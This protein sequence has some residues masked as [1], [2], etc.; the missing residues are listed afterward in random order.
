MKAIFLFLII[1]IF[2]SIPNSFG[3]KKKIDSLHAL[4]VKNQNN[5]LLKAE[6]FA[7]E[8]L[9]LSKKLKNDSLILISTNYLISILY[10]KRESKEVLK[11]VLQN[12]NL[13]KKLSSQKYLCL[14]YL[15][16]AKVQRILG[17]YEK[18]IKSVEKGLLISRNKGFLSLEHQL[19]N[20]KAVLLKKTKRFKD[21]KK[22][23]KKLLREEKFNDLNNISF[24]YNS[25][26]GLYLR[27]DRKIDSSNYFFKKG[28][29]L[30][31]KTNNKYLQTLLFTNYS[32]F[33]SENGNPK[34]ALNYLKKAKELAESSYNFKSLFFINSSLGYYYSKNKNYTEAIKHYKIALNK[35]GKYADGVQI[36]NNY[37]LLADV[38]YY[39]KQYKEGFLYV[40]KVIY[41]N[42]SLFNIEK[43]KTFEKLQ[44]E[45][46]VEK[47]NNKITYLEKEKELKN[48]RLKLV[49]GIGGLVV[50]IL[51][52]LVFIYRNKIQAQKRI[53]IQNKK[54]YQQE[55]EQLQQAQKIKRIEGFIAGEE[56]EKNRIATELHDGIGGEL[57][58]IQHFVSALPNSE[59]TD[60]L[61]K[62]IA[63]VSKEVRLLAHSLSS[64]FSIQQP[65]TNLLATLQER[66]K[67][68][69]TIEVAIY[70]E[71]E[72]DTLP[73]DKKLF[74]YRAIQEIVTNIYKHA[75]ANLV[76]ISLTVAN[77]I[78]LL[79]EDNGI[80][81]DTKATPNGIG[82]ENIKEKV[83]SFK[84]T[85]EVD[86]F[87]GKGTTVI[88]KISK[89]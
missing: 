55:K 58:G 47:K 39:D 54:L 65:F 48:Q 62:D 1:I 33:F 3:Q 34:E 9:N 5:N 21:S 57:S 26:A 24:T 23:L 14:S 31:E 61:S 50:L 28:I 75:K 10:K 72:I 86:S 43:N 63:A 30:A 8:A 53:A 22:L 12:R 29:E 69:F 18:S 25:L 80:G 49:Y 70:P 6:L 38:L 81:F 27:Q 52:L 88:I 71:N 78:T 36:A 45:F 19:L 82:L 84:G 67:N 83:T 73:D 4:Y 42:D 13:A 76:S 15:Y 79:I 17:D 11:L 44:T 20:C 87:A 37:W 64:H 60:Q 16:L 35:Y 32:D 66:Y 68:H 85:F 74:L 7:N 77:E 89:K 59:K 41:L 40:E 56:K 51:I 46:E 2:I